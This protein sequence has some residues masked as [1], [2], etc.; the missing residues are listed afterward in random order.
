M[1]NVMKMAIIEAIQSLRSAGLSCRAIARRLGIH[2]DTVARHVR[3]G[4]EGDSKPAKAPISPA[5][6][7]EVAGFGAPTGNLPVAQASV[8]APWLPWLLEQ[9]AR[10]LTAKRIHQD[11]QA[12]FPE[13]GSVS[14]DS[15]RR[16]L[17]KQGATLPIPFRRMECAAGHEAQ[18]DFGTG[19]A[20]VGPDGK[21]RR[22]HVLRVVLS[23]SRKGYS[24]SV[25]HQ[26]TDCFL[27]SLEN[28]FE[29][30]GGV[31]RT[32][33]VDNL[34]AAVLQ[35]DWFDPEINPKLAAFCRHYG[36]VVLPTRP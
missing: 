35:A 8:A 4:R 9:H 2:R 33:V 34:K 14:Y 24:E 23:H 27:Q 11:L 5:G 17:R 19:A 30:F 32:I 31:P 1:A 6:S 3:V 20:V 21:R 12:E 16:L 10:G 15:V 26:S 29:H 13:A 7:D 36:T 25:F 18:I 28:A 22:T